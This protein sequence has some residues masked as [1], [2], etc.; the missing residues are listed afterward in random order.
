MEPTV[1][2]SE[3]IFLHNQAMMETDFTVPLHS[4]LKIINIDP[5]KPKVV[6][7]IIVILE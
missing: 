4:S 3:T 5:L 1:N 2:Y 7:I 6:Y